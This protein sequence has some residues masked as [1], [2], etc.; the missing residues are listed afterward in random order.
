LG[1]SAS[2]II[3]ITFT[4]TGGAPSEILTINDDAY[5]GPHVVG[6]A[7]SAISGPQVS[8]SGLT[9]GSG[10]TTLGSTLVGHTV[11]P[12]A[13][14][15]ENIGESP[16]VFTG[17]AA[18]GDFSQTNNCTTLA[19]RDSCT[20]NISFT[21]TATGDRTG[22]LTITDNAHDSPQV[23]TLLGDG[24]DFSLATTASSASVAAGQSAKYTIT[25]TP[26]WGFN[27]QISLACSGAPLYATCSLPS[28]TVTLDGIN[29]P[30][31]TI[32]VA[33]TAASFLPPAR[34][35][36]PTRRTPLLLL[37][38]L[39]LLI[40]LPLMAASQRRAKWLT[41]LAAALLLA[42]LLAGC[43]GGSAGGGGGGNPGTPAGTY[44]LAVTGSSGSL[45]HTLNLTLTVN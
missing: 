11:G 4:P 44:T 31:V 45:S 10:I 1:P 6:L 30:T 17:V 9:G 42:A 14:S 19:F 33:T 18:T 28:G 2:C 29:A 20:I 16:L 43:G 15:V 22:T 25:L 5:G 40:F 7:G 12:S 26:D 41:P 23:V 27:S 37:T 8:I 24:M 21:P 34:H 32:T 13:V 36:S 35:F 39:S 38:F 3:T